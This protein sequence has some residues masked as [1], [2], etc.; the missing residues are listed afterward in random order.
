MNA[1]RQTK[2]GSLDR[3]FLRVAAVYRC[4]R[5]WGMSAAECVERLSQRMPKKD[6]AALVS[7]WRQSKNLR[8]LPS[9][10]A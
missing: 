10:T 1:Y 8:D 5:R 2:D 4:A 6:A 7:I 9:F 3:Q